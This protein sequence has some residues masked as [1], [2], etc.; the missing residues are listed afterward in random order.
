MKI[1]VGVLG[2]TGI[3]GQQY[4]QRLINHPFFEL[5]FL[6]ASPESVGKTYA[7]AVEGR[8]HGHDA[9]PKAIG[10]LLVHGVDDI[11]IALRECRLVFS[12]VSADVAKIY[13]ERYAEAGLA[14]MS[15]ASYHRG[16]PDVPVLIPEVNADHL[17][18][19]RIQQKNRGWQRGFIV[20]KPNCSLQSYM[21]PLF[22]LHRQFHMKRLIVNTLQ[23]VSG[24]G[25]PG[26]SSLTI[27]DNV[28]PFIAGEEEKSEDEPLKILGVIQ[29]EGIEH[30]K[31]P[32]IAAHCHRV[33]VIDG[34]LASVSVEFEKKPTREEILQIWSTFSCPYALPS[35]PDQLIVYRQESDRPQ[36]RLDR[37]AGRG[38]AITV[39]RLRCC[40]VFDFRFTALSHNTIRGAAGGGILNAELLVSENFL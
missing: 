31:S 25:F 33:P 2:A 6:A 12:A 24:A 11:A 22:P 30:A 9:C 32:M 36:P 18:M 8:W 1:P 23:A 29:G 34:H 21:I 19:I 35:S 7:Q 38:M 39:G 37:M 26:V 28:V 5:S 14:V 17:Q 40:P 16:T 13:E 15:N 10:A 3:V 20:V 4:V 27:S